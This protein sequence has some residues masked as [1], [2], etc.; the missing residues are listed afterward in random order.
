MNQDSGTAFLPR[1]FWLGMLLCAAASSQ[2]Q[3]NLPEDVSAALRA[4]QIDETSIS[5]LVVPVQAG[6][7]RLAHFDQRPMAP[8]STMKLVTTLVALEELG[9]V[10][11]WRTQ[12]LSAQPLKGDTLRGPLYLRGGGDP[13]L[14]WDGLRAM[15]R[16]LRAQG[17]R[18]LDGDLILDRSFF[19]PSRPDI[20]APPFDESPD[21][22]YNVIPDA[23]LLNGNLI[24][25][26][27]D[28]GQR[29]SSVRTQPPLDH[30]RFDAALSL[31]DSRC[32]AWD[33]NWDRPRTTMKADGATTV[34]L[35]GAFPRNCKTT[36]RLNLLERNLYIERF[37][38]AFWKE[39]GGSWKGRASDGLTAPDAHLLVE[40]ASATLAQTLRPVNKASDNAMARTLYLTLGTRLAVDGRSDSNLGKA[41]AA[42]RNWF[43]RHGIAD[44]GLV[45]ENGSGLSRLE[46]IS[47]RQLGALL[48][49]GARSNWFAEY[50]SSFPIAAIDG[51]M[52]KRLQQSPAAARARIKTGTLRDAVS[53]AGYVRDINNQDW[54]VVAIVNHPEAKKGRPALDALI[55]WVAG[56]PD[57]TPER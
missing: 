12:L 34:V 21:A 36:T 40:R 24:E 54:I 15:F 10:F 3:G 50:A 31:D 57:A 46:R 23:L 37:L 19:Q 2:A 28:S 9:P 13:D 43:A 27:I 52:R 48:Q 30:V 26:T 55:N 20:G 14:N 32:E 47:P 35:R 49:V 11:R 4:A 5:A 6:M 41:E 42:V 1:M 51:A 33:D 39:L 53:A 38:R 7:P 8:A 17:V 29:Q 22:Y 18:K 45:M 16:S 25:F 44:D 56:G